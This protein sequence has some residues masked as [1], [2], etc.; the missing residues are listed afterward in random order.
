MTTITTSAFYERSTRALN[1]LRG[2]AESLQG[3]IGT[4][5][6]MVRG[7]DD[8]VGASQLRSLS[9][10]SRFA[11]ISAVA[12]ARVSSDLAL[13]DSGLSDFAAYVTRVKELAVQAGSDT[14]TSAQRSGIGVEI[15]SIYAELIRLSNSRDSA[16]DALFGGE[17]TGDAYTIDAAGLPVYAGTAKAGELALGDGQSVIR[18]VTGPEFLNFTSPNGPTTCLRW[19]ASWGRLCRAMFPIQR[20]SRAMLWVIW[21]PGSNPSPPRRRWSAAE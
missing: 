13:T 7:S 10:E 17:S 11:E 16:G 2:R 3:A 6:R 8:P 21:M 18:G 12:G 19:Y 14:L 15:K 4:G 5:Q 9:R 1:E 20:S